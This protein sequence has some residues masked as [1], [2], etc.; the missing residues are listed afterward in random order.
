MWKLG[1]LSCGATCA[2]M[3]YK[4]AWAV[5]QVSTKR[6]KLDVTDASHSQ[7]SKATDISQTDMDDDDWGHFVFID[8]PRTPA[9]LVVHKPSVAVA[10]ATMKPEA[11][12][13]RR[14]HVLLR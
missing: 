4:C 12:T 1:L 10:M 8:E 5:E 3:F 11:A 9:V 7:D 6:I 2:F 14:G 13:S